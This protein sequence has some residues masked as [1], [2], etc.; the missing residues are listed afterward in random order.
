MATATYRTK[1]VITLSLSQD[2]ADFIQYLLKEHIV[3]SY[4][5]DCK[6]SETSKDMQISES[7]FNALFNAK[8]IKRQK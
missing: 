1:K 3:K 7:I 8:S 4:I 5:T 6:E 2:E